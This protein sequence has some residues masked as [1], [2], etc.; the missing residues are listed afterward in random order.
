MAKEPGLT[1]ISGDQWASSLLEAARKD[2]PLVTEAVFARL[3]VLLGGQLS[4][5]DLT[6]ANLKAVATQLIGDAVPEPPKPE[7]TQ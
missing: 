7:E 5:R 2:N 4:E 6:P 1:G 3:A